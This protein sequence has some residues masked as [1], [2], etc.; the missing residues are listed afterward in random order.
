MKRILLAIA[1]L[2]F[3]VAIFARADDSKDQS[4]KAIAK[5]PPAV[6][7]IT[8]TDALRWSNMRL[9]AQ[10]KRAQAEALNA[11]AQTSED[12]AALFIKAV[13]DRACKEAGVDPELYDLQVGEKGELLLALKKQAEPK[14]P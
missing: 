1:I 5:T 14:K 11:Q 7:A 8:E 9:D 6:L 12:P 3:S 13:R 10:S 2:S 4:P